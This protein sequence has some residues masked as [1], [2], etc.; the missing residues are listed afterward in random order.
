VS[1]SIFEENSYVR[2]YFLDEKK[3]NNHMNETS[4]IMGSSL[5]FY[6]TK[7]YSNTYFFE[8]IRA[9]Y[10]IYTFSV[11]NITG[12]I[13]GFEFTDDLDHFEDEFKKGKENW[14][15]HRDKRPWDNGIYKEDGFSIDDLKVIFKERM[16]ELNIEEDNGKRILETPEEEK[17][18]IKRE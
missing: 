16:K 7:D 3:M 5:K 12:E 14:F 18:R 9:N 11:L 4:Y 8:K 15:S 2:L 13:D 6:E 17:E 10:T 1:V